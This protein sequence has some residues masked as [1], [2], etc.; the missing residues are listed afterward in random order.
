MSL[1]YSDPLGG[2][3]F[4]GLAVIASLGIHGTL[5]AYTLRTPIAPPR[6]ETDDFGLTGAI[7]F[8]LSDII[9]APS[10]AS[11]DSAEVAEAVD[12]P[13]ITESAEA[14]DPSKA[15]EEPLL[16]QTPYQVE[17]DEL[18]FGVANPDASEDAEKQAEEIATEFEEEKVDQESTAGSQAADASNASVSGVDAI[19]KAAE[20]KAA[21]VGITAEQRREI[22]DWQKSI[23]LK[24]HENKRYP[25]LARRKRIEGEVKL[26]FTIDRYGKIISKEIAKSS[27]W[28]VLDN[29][30]LKVL[31]KIGKLPTPPN[32][33]TGDSFTLV[34]PIRYRFK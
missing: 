1:T 14:V 18:K 7:M 10:E 12:A 33:L 31:Q 5:A 4:W 17:D 27:G 16:N 26:Q 30:A 2:R 24:I 32:H 29:A 21:S 19:E 22:G 6:S 11:E 13:T 15:S 28:P 20:A 34:I 25:K 23:V 8:D 9:A 3:I